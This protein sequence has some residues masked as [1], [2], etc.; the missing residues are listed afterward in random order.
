[1]ITVPFLYTQNIS[2]KSFGKPV[3]KLEWGFS[4]VFY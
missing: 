4:F 1:M 2:C 3:Y